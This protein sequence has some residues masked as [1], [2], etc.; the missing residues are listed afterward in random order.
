MLLE[1]KQCE[2]KAKCVFLLNKYKSKYVV[3]PSGC[4]KQTSCIYFG[5]HD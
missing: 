2:L 1:A 4:T 3:Q 5:I